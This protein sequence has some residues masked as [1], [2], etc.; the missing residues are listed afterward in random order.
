MHIVRARLKPCKSREHTT[1]WRS[2]LQFNIN[3]VIWRGD[4][5]TPGESRAGDVLL[6]PLALAAFWTL[7]YQLVLVARWPAQT[8]VWCFFATALGGLFLLARLWEKTDA[9]PGHG[10][11]FH[12]SQILLVTMGMACAVTILFVR[13]P[14]QDD[15]VYFHRALAQLSALD[16]PIFLRQTSVDMDAAAFSP[17]HLATSH[18]VLMAL[19]G[20]YLRIDPLYSYQVIGHVSPVSSPDDTS[21][22]PGGYTGIAEA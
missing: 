3:D 11:R 12:P 16:K 20:H 15:I 9:M 5:E 10:Y 21:R 6:L 18:E 7:A 2:P 1:W 8:T 14:N 4:S 22:L 17:V 19:L 13:R